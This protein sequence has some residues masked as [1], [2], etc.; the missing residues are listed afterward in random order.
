MKKEKYTKFTKKELENEI[1]AK[2]RELYDAKFDVK[3]GEKKNYKQL[4]FMKKTI[5]RMLTVLNAGT[6]KT[7]SSTRNLRK[8]KNRQT[9]KL[10]NKQ[11]RLKK[12]KSLKNNKIFKDL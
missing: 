2:R 8:K 9:K 3:S 4:K 1:K 10:I 6:Y 11:K 12:R 7:K 5:A